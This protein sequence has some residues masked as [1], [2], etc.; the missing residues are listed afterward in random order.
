MNRFTRYLLLIIALVT[1]LTAGCNSDYNDGYSQAVREVR[2]AR[3]G[4]GFAAEAGMQIL[5]GVDAIPTDPK[6]SADWNAGY[7]DGYRSELSK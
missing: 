1:P 6:K 4:G 3:R 7:R 5:N 2:E